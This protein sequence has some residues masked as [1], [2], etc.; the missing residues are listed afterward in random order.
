MILSSFGETTDIGWIGVPVLLLF[1]IVSW[2]S[3]SRKQKKEKEYS[4]KE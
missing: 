4:D 2:W 3:I 1:F